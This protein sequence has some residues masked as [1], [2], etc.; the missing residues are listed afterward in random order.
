MVSCYIYFAY[1][2]NNGD[3]IVRGIG[4][5]EGV[6]NT[7]WT[8]FS[9]SFAVFFPRWFITM[10]LAIVYFRWFR[11]TRFLISV[12][13]FYEN[14]HY[15]EKIKN[16]PFYFFFRFSNRTLSK[17]CIPHSGSSVVNPVTTMILYWHAFQ[18]LRSACKPIRNH[19]YT[20]IHDITHS[21]YTLTQTIGWTRSLE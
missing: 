15:T 4:D 5:S 16:V 12:Y 7:D 21:F 10:F 13:A 11:K 19:R 9:D 1:S 6:Q 3:T 18:I 14:T 2:L 20:Y 17:A 8:D